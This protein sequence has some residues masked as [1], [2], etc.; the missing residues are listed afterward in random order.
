MGPTATSRGKNSGAVDGVQ[1]F[2]VDVPM[3]GLFLPIE[4][5]IQ[6][7]PQLA[8]LLDSLLRSSSARSSVSSRSSR[9]STIKSPAS[10]QLSQR[11]D[12]PGNRRISMERS[13]SLGTWSPANGAREKDWSRRRPVTERAERGTGISGVSERAVSTGSGIETGTERTGISSI[14]GES[15]TGTQGN[16]LSTQFNSNAVSA[17][18]SQLVEMRQKYEDSQREMQEKTAILDELRSTVNEL[19]PLLEEYETEIADKDHKLQKQKADFEKAREEWRDLIDLMLQAHQE[20]EQYYEEQ[21][22]QL[23]GGSEEEALRK[24][25][26][27]VK[28]L[29][30]MAKKLEEEVS[31]LTHALNEVKM[32]K[33]MEEKKLQALLEGRDIE[34]RI[35]RETMEALQQQDQKKEVKKESTDEQDEGILYNKELLEK[36]VVQLQRD[37]NFTQEENLLLKEMI[38]DLEL[39]L[40]YSESELSLIVE[41]NLANKVKG[42]A[43]EDDGH[44]KQQVEELQHQLEMRPTFDELVELQT[45]LEE[46]EEIHKKELKSTQDEVRRLIGENRD[47]LNKLEKLLKES[48]LPVPSPDADLYDNDKSPVGDEPVDSG[49]PIYKATNK[50]D[51]SSGKDDWCGLCERD[52]HSSINCPYENDVF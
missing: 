4:R 23:R 12:S 30:E 46:L 44:L 14:T 39:K 45:S 43:L 21:I 38:A 28:K 17:L 11:V 51:P 37:L 52:G 34:L 29:E 27:A 32:E 6:L 33:V 19:Q 16:G 24:L 49:L 31:R 13:R 42:V 22:E 10:P 1:Y 48:E 2:E 35:L 20:N 8:N 5:L 9:M 40:T 15:I 36:K 18:E 47:L 25:E 50:V 3:T 26:E 7:N 41:K